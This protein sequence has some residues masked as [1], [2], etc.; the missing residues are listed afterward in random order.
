VADRLMTDAPFGVLL[1]GGLDSSLVSAIAVR[2]LRARGVEKIMSF[3][4]GIEGAP[5]LVAAKKVADLLGTD[6]Y[7][8][9]FT[10]QVRQVT[11]DELSRVCVIGVEVR[12]SGSTKKKSKGPC[13]CGRDL[14][15]L[16]G[17]PL[18]RQPGS[19]TAETSRSW[20]PHRSFGSLVF[21][22]VAPARLG[23]TS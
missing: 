21:D 15:A 12:L 18:A 7:E 17:E 4:I 23:T 20:P 16:K 9:Y 2:L 13:G 8:F 22:A 6:H 3:T 5:D 11:S 14:G 1:S 19:S 10:P